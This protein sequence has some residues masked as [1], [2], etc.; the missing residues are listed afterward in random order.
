M[1]SQVTSADRNPESMSSQVATT[2]TL[3]RCGLAAGPLFLLIF[4]TQILLR[5]EF[6]FTRDEPSLLSI[7]PLGW[8]QI[9]NRMLGGLLVI[10]GAR[11][12]RRLLRRSKAGFWG[13]L[14]LQVFGICEVGLGIF[15]VDP[16]RS[17]AS[18]A[19]HG[20]SHIVFGAIGFLALMAACFVFA[21]SFHVQKKESM[22]HFLQADVSGGIPQRW[23]HRSP[24]PKYLEHSTLSEP[25]ILPRMDLGVIDLAAIL[26]AAP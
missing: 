22:S 19:L 23:P 18:M 4:A 7:G 6:R 10:A 2:G 21:P 11:G 9:G 24:W 26:S 3:L 17:P 25:G 16:A 20:T 13:P 12:I 14:L 1:H 5:P 15:V 8:I